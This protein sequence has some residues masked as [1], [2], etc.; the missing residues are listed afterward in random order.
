MVRRKAT[1]TKKD[2]EISH[3]NVLI[4]MTEQIEAARISEI[5]PGIMKKVMVLGRSILLAL[6][7]GRYYAV[8]A[9][10]PHLEGDLSSG[11]LNGTILTCPIHNS[12]FDIRDG[13]VIRWTDQTGI[14]LEYA[15][16]AHPPKP[17]KHY[18]V[19]IDG[20]TIFIEM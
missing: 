12:Q 17:L 20:D 7:N 6:V 15:S 11:T 4:A 5:K 1:I 19:R 8:D 9:V 10:C 2:P 18:P 13:H 16:R 14:R 3:Q